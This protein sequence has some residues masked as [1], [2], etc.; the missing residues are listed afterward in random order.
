MKHKRYLLLLF[1]AENAFVLWMDA[2]VP[3]YIATIESCTGKLAVVHDRLLLYMPQ[4]LK[5]LDCRYYT[6]SIDYTC[7]IEEGWT[8]LVVL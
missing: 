4:W 1:P 5:H 2:L 7:S 8:H 3:K 6:C